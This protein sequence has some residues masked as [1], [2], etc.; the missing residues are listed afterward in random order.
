MKKVFILLFLV[1]SVRTI[2][3]DTTKTELSDITELGKPDGTPSSATI[4]PDGARIVSGDGMVELIFPEGA[5]SKPTVITIQP[6]TNHA[7]NGTGKAYWFEPSGTQF[8]KPVKIIFHYSEEEG[9]SCPPEWKSLGIQQSNGKWSFAEYEEFDSIGRTL[10]GYIHH[11]SGVSNLDGVR[12]TF[13]NHDLRVTQSTL[14]ELVDISG[15]VDATAYDLAQ[16]Y[17]NTPVLWYVN[18]ILNGDEHTGKLRIVELPNYGRA[19]KYRT[20]V[21]Q[22]EYT[23][24]NY[25]PKI[26]PVVITAEI[27][28][29]DKKGKRKLR[30]KIRAFVN[31]TDYYEVALLYDF[32]GRV[33]MGSKLQD[34]AIFNVR[35]KNTGISVTDIGN[36]H[37][38]VLKQG[39]RI[40][41]KEMN[42]VD[43]AEGPVHLTP[44]IL[45]EKLS[46][47][48]PH[49]VFF[50]FEQVKVLWL[51]FQY[52]CRGGTI[53]ELET[54]HQDTLPIEINIIANGQ[55][56]NY[57]IYHG[58]EF[59]YRLKVIPL[60]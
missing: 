49:E 26:A 56:Q 40:G 1:I 15:M 23:A 5:L 30:K 9:E 2:A 37:P 6:I 19:G 27:Y 32:T 57:T 51:K 44:R 13:S 16:L 42:Y 53:T 48:Y 31:I 4:G 21:F 24:P 52:K 34:S 38:R 45:N 28:R 54:F 8:A 41:C 46:N 14:L 39:Q 60:R 47:D 58:S 25:L 12:I 33:G 10:T 3:Q 55:R 50:E 22:G 7:P 35:L 36:S 11:F 18:G 17:N 29:T 20:K 43:N 59:K